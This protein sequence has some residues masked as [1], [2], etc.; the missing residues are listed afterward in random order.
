[1]GTTSLK[2]DIQQAIANNVKEFKANYR[3]LIFDNDNREHIKNL[4]FI[5]NLNIKAQDNKLLYDVKI[6]EEAVKLLSLSDIKQIQKVDLQSRIKNLFIEKAVQFKLLKPSFDKEKPLTAVQ[7]VKLKEGKR[8][9]IKII[10]ERLKESFNLKTEL[11]E[12]QIYLSLEAELPEIKFNREL[13]EAL[14]N[15]F[16]ELDVLAIVPNFNDVYD[17][18]QGVRFFMGINLN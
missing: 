1:M 12:S 2:C 13:L 6:N 11:K 18:I 8:L 3:S 5:E 17:N 14:E 10:Q 15:I 4:F 7:T 16:S 9:A